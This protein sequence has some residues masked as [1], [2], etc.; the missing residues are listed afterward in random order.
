MSGASVKG[1]DTARQ[2]GRVIVAGVF[3]L[4]GAAARGE[5]SDAQE[6]LG[7]G[8]FGAAQDL[9]LAA[10]AEV[11]YRDPDYARVVFEPYRILGDAR[12]GLEDWTGA[13]EAY[14]RARG[15]MH[16]RDAAK[17]DDAIEILREE[18]RALVNIG[19]YENARVRQESAFE[20]SAA[21][22]GDSLAVVPSLMDLGHW[23]RD[24]R[25]FSLAI[26][27]FEDA[28]DI[29]EGVDAID[30][31]L[32]AQ[33]LFELG[34]VHRERRW[35]APA[36]AASF[37]PRPLATSFRARTAGDPDGVRR[38][39][40]T[41]IKGLRALRRAMHA[42]EAEANVDPQAL[43]TA[44][45]AYADLLTLYRKHRPADDLY[46]AS[47]THLADTAPELLDGF[48]GRPVNLFQPHP[49]SPTYNADFAPRYG[50][51]NF[52][53][54]VTRK[55]LVRDIRVDEIDAEIDVLVF[56]YRGAAR[57]GRYRPRFING[58]PVDTPDVPIS[59]TFKY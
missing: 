41:R 25:H 9:A 7:A 12:M 58:A 49:G 34:R 14:E 39:E 2:W 55:G 43:A 38:D 20:I 52:T 13:L 28:L 1:M 17:R 47:W 45:I 29:V 4:S 35:P 10:I 8:E 21:R 50:R 27:T 6:R 56:K 59:F 5:I 53:A 46:R 54:T 23:Y 30:H 48:F 15:A 40:R 22:H 11:D 33:L 37:A 42:F 18:A 19:D 57:D 44:R 36:G 24:T 26:R 31:A 3:V 51:I 16:D 32:Q